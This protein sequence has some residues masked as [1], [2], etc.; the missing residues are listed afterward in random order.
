MQIIEAILTENPCFKEGAPLQPQG[1]ML[2]SVGTPQP[3]AEVFVKKWNKPTHTRSCVHAFIDANDGAIWQTLPWDIRAWHCGKGSNGSGNNSHIGIEMCEP[4]TIKYTGGASFTCSDIPQATATAMRT[5]KAAV[6]IFAALAIKYGIDPRTPGAIISH[7]E[8]HK[9]GIASNHADPEHLWRGLGMKLS[10]DQF[11]AD[12]ADAMQIPT[13][14]PTPVQTIIPPT[15]HSIIGQVVKLE[16]GDALN[17]RTG[18]GTQYPNLNAWPTLNSGNAFEILGTD[19]S[20]AWFYINIQG[21][22]YNEFG[23]VYSKYVE[24]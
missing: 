7:S 21:A 6:E 12:V 19:E 20:R 11:R 8:G 3:S 10:M 1:L 23:W 16:K 17:V 9:L 24:I 14:T 22:G 18:P 2:H 5:Y 15:H 13:P 4:A